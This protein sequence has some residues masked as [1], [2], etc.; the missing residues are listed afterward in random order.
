MKAFTLLIKNLAFT[1]LVPG[2][3]V[4]WVPLNLFERHPQWP[5]V[6]AWQQYTGAA[7]FGLGAL[8]FLH[9]QWLFAVKGQG[10]PAPIDPPKKFV[11]RGLYKWVRNPM[12]LAVFSL[13]GAEA[14][15]LRSGHIAVYFVLLVCIIHVWVLAYEE[16][17]LR[18]NFGA[19]YEDYK[20]DVPRWLPR[21][22]KPPLQTVAPFPVESAKR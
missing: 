21:K 5:A 19:I 7:L 20:R 16:T 12:Y 2:F 14:L 18:R 22:P 4:G 17:V 11:R 1:I 13:V 3:I 10:T 8:V 15:F 6:W 9:C